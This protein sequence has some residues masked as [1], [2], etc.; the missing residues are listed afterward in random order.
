MK[1]KNEGTQAGLIAVGAIVMLGIGIAVGTCLGYHDTRVYAE[2]CVSTSV[3]QLISQHK[4]DTLQ[5]EKYG[6]LNIFEDGTW[7]YKEGTQPLYFTDSDWTSNF[8]I[9]Q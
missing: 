4:K 7:S 6:R 8:D 2:N 1:K 9:N 3:S 5:L